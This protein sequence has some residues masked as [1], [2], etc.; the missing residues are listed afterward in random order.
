MIP[1][2]E[3]QQKLTTE[4]PKCDVWLTYPMPQDTFASLSQKISS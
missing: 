1:R 2:L 4:K 3:S